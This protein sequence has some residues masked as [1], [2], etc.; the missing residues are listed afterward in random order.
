LETGPAPRVD[1]LAT[2]ARQLE[3]QSLTGKL[4]VGIDLVNTASIADSLSHFGERFLQRIFTVEEIAYAKSSPVCQLERLAA[5]FAAKEATI[6]ALSLSEAG[7]PWTDLEVVR[8]S[9]GNCE[10]R[11]HGVA[12][13]VANQSGIAT[14]CLSMSHDNGYATAIVIAQHIANH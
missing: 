11:L 8:Q 3:A 9:S 13:A 4:R 14:V 7:V 10:M 6:K 12:R 5:R 2:M 1:A